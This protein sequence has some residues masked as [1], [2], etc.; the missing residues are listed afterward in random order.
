MKE[1]LPGFGAGARPFV[2]W[3]GGK[4]KLA[5]LVVERAPRGF[6]RYH[7]PFVGGGAVFFA[8]AASGRAAGARL[9][10]ANSEL[11]EAYRVVRDEPAALIA[12]LQEF[13]AEYGAR[14]LQG[15]AA[16]YYAVRSAVAGDSVAAA[17]RLLFLNRTCYNGLYRVN[18]SGGFNVPHGRYANPRI[19]DADG[20]MAASGALQ[21]CELVSEDFEAACA[22]ARPGDFVYLDPPYQ[23]LTRT[24]NFTSY[25]SGEFGAA[26]QERLRDAFDVMT[27]R[28]VA[29]LLSNSDHA[30]IR[31]LYADRGYRCEV[32][33]MSRA[34]NSVGSR[35]A[36]I[37]E[38]LIANFDRPEVQ[39][40]FSG[41][42]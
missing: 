2:K 38:L 16:M 42:L 7:E 9:N 10:D 4:G 34:I 6:G 21:G 27:A 3:A 32:V 14:A 8:M 26:E 35:R 11:I 12:A 19:C 28:G 29:A 39:D 40:A 30:V 20:L 24:A 37:T 33:A 13:A 41:R 17:A 15:R 25:T 22:E 18:A 1:A 31:A 36:P 5:P 23:P